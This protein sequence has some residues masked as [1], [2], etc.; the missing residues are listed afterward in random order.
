MPDYGSR[1]EYLASL[2]DKPLRLALHE[3]ALLTHQQFAKLHPPQFTFFSLTSQTYPF[4]SSRLYLAPPNFRNQLK[5]ALEA[6]ATYATQMQVIVRKA[7]ALLEKKDQDLEYEY[8]QEP[9]KRWR[10]WYDLNR[11]RL[12]AMSVRTREYVQLCRL[13]LRYP[14]KVLGPE[15]NYLAFRFRPTLR[16]SGC[17]ADAA[18]AKR[19]LQRCIDNHP[20][21][22]WADFALWELEVP[23]GLDFIGD[24]ILPPPPPTGVVVGGAPASG[25]PAF[26]KL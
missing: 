24:V 16:V 3:V 7:L 8:K 9:S 5:K 20:K 18:E 1:E 17:E 25:P 12:L 26:P 19:L 6:E 2:Q 11:G 23:M 10:A 22:P 13:I 4:D 15:T 14:E 21:T